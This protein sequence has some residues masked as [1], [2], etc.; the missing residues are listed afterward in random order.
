MKH[1]IITIMIMAVILS[2]SLFWVKIAK[3]EEIAKGIGMP[4]VFIE[5][6]ERTNSSWYYNWG[7]CPE[8]ES[9]CVPMSWGGADPNLPVDYN[10]YVML[11]NEPDRP[12]Q[13][14]ITPENALIIYKALK[15][16]YPSAKWVV[17]NTFYPN[18]LY[19]FYDLCTADA[20]CIIPRYWGIHAY[21]GGADFLPILQRE[22]IKMHN[23]VGGTF[24]ITEFASVYGDVSTDEGLVR[25]FKSQNW[26]ERYAIFCN[27]AQGTEPWYPKSWNVQLVDWD[28]GELTQIGEWYKYGLFKTFISIVQK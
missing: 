4:Y 14:N 16:K 23:K 22:F 19:K 7:A 13:S 25:F 21:I 26:I 9:R 6:L 3:G 17:G 15:L 27:R 11:F 28:T 2:T 20:D 10:N 5:D 24:W 8:A 18:W 1:K 12:D